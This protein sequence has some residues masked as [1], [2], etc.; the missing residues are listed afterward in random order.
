MTE[1]NNVDH[2]G[3]AGPDYREDFATVDCDPGKPKIMNIE[4]ARGLYGN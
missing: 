2:Y 4:K 1:A 3:W